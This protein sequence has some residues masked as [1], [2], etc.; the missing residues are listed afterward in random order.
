LNLNFKKL[1][2]V[3]KTE[4]KIHLLSDRF[5]IS[6]DIESKLLNFINILKL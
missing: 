2:L 4:R 6:K 3:R 1:Y 5:H